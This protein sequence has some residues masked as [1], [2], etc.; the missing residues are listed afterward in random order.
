MD[1]S[2]LEGKGE[3]VKDYQKHIAR[4]NNMRPVVA[5][6]GYTLGGEFYFLSA[7]HAVNTVLRKDRLL[8]CPKCWA[9][10]AQGEIE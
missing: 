7:E 5:Y 6:C 3:K 10:L 9:K 1:E 4:N 2:S 8:P